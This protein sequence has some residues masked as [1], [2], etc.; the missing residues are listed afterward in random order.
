M[1]TGF[2][3]IVVRYVSKK[4]SNFSG[5]SVTPASGRISC[6]KYIFERVFFSQN[7]RDKLTSLKEF[8]KWNLVYRIN[9]KMATAVRPKLPMS[10]VIFLRGRFFRR[11]LA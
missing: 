9:N 10:L 1:V 2:V 8:R 11:R 3:R 6:F 5:R 4:E 7:S